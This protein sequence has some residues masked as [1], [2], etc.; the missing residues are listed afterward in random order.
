[1]PARASIGI[2]AGRSNRHH[3]LVERG[4]VHT[5]LVGLDVREPGPQD[6]DVP[7]IG[8]RRRLPVTTWIR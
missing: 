4:A 8:S 3:Q 1:M 5:T 6:E 7:S 2:Q